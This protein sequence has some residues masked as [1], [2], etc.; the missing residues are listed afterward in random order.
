MAMDT[1]VNIGDGCVFC[2]R[3]TAPGSGRYVNRVPGSHNPANQ[4]GVLLTGWA[5]AECLA[6]DPDEVCECAVCPVE[7]H[8][9][10]EYAQQSGLCHDCE[11]AGHVAR[12]LPARHVYCGLCGAAAVEVLDD[13]DVTHACSLCYAARN[14]TTWRYAHISPRTV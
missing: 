3:D 8:D 5:C 12:T 1:V 6:P 9:C 2:L 14:G 13:A 11:E 7:G 4:P 10:E